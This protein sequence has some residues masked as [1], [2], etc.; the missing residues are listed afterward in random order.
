MSL[1][2]FTVLL[3]ICLW[4]RSEV[5]TAWYNIRSF[6][7]KCP[8][9]LKK[10]WGWSC[11]K[12]KTLN[13]FFGWPFISLPWLNE[14]DTVNFASFVEYSIVLFFLFVNHGFHV[15]DDFVF[16]V[17]MWIFDIDDKIVLKDFWFFSFQFNFAASGGLRQTHTWIRKAVPMRSAQLDQRGIHRGVGGETC[18]PHRHRFKHVDASGWNDSNQRNA[19]NHDGRWGNRATHL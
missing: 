15:P 10:K 2:K 1:R 13:T 14:S 12:M 19:E 17:H 5:P 8:I 3:G 18:P 7:K 6:I 4:M 9:K 11:R 16:Y